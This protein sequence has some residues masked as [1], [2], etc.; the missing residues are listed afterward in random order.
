M[1]KAGI[2]VHARHLETVGWERLIWGTP[3]D[4]RLG[5]VSKVVEFLLDESGDEPITAI[6]FGCGP[7]VKE[8]LSEGEYTKQYL[9]RHLPNLVE[10]PRF[11]DRMDDKTVA[12]LRERLE[13]I[14]ITPVLKRS[15]D[16]VVTASKM[17][18]E[19]SVSRVYQ[20]TCASHAPRCVQIQSAARAKGLLPANQQW[21]LAADDQCFEDADP[22]STLVMEPPHRGDDPMFGFSPSLPELL[23]SYQ[24]GLSSEDKQELARI[25][26]E[27][28]FERVEHSE[29]RNFSGSK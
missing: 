6:V 7:S 20:V 12:R 10:F 15:I 29:V 19:R 24:Y 5:N 21:F 22:F 13:G 8:G 2:L 16:E 26:G 28:M 4:D 1:A 25:V 23:R 3:Q 11:K 9:L 17:F 14:I 27:F 18:D